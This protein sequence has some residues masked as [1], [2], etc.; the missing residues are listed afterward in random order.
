MAHLI[1]EYTLLSL[2]F[3]LPKCVIRAKDPRLHQINIAAP[4][5]LNPGPVPQGI[6]KVELILPYKA[7]DEATLHNQPSKKM[8]KKKKK[9][10]KWWKCLILRTILRCSTNLSPQ[11]LSPMISV[12]SPQL[13]KPDAR[14][15][16]HPRSFG[17]TTQT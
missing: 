8:K 15:F 17:D 2:S 5:F 12:T 4:G 3:Q 13:S 10:K 7:E 16:F 9:K 11:R 6:L 1:L 14:G